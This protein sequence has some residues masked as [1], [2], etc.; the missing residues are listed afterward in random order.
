MQQMVVIASHRRCLPVQNHHDGQLDW[1][2]IRVVVEQVRTIRRVPERRRVKLAGVFKVSA[3]SGLEVS[4]QRCPSQ[5]VE[6][7]SSDDD[8]IR[9]ER[10]SAERGPRR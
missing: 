1:I 4:V 3:I 2:P 5:F 9:N 6:L 7:A 10:P 8:V